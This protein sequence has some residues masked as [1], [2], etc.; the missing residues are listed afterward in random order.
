[1]AK[2]DRCD[3][4]MRAL[5]SASFGLHRLPKPP[6]SLLAGAQAGHSPSMIPCRQWYPCL[7]R[8]ASGHQLDGLSFLPPCPVSDVIAVTAHDFK[9]RVTRPAGAYLQRMVVVHAIREVP[10]VLG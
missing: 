4:S 7:S 5:P 8:L 2:G 6:P 10:H 1:M 3:R 9:P